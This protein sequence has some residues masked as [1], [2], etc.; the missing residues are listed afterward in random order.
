MIGSFEQIIEFI[1][2]ETDIHAFDFEINKKTKFKAYIFIKNN[3]LNI[4]NYNLII[5]YKN[6]NIIYNDK[7]NN[8]NKIFY[9]I[10]EKGFYIIEIKSKNNEKIKDVIYLKINCYEKIKKDNNNNN[11]ILNFGYKYQDI[12]TE[13]NFI[14]EF[15]TKFYIFICNNHINLI[16]MPYEASIYYNLN[17]TIKNYYFYY[18]NTSFGFYVEVIFKYKWVKTLIMEYR[19][20]Y[21]YYFIYTKFGSFKCS[22]DFYFY[23]FDNE[24]TNNIFRGNYLKD[25]ILWSETIAFPNYSSLSHIIFNNI[26][27]LIK[28]NNKIDNK[29]FKYNN[30]LKNNDLI[31][32]HQINKKIDIIYL[33]DSTGS[34]GEEVNNAS[35]LAID[36]ADSL[37]KKYP[38]HDF[39]FGFIYYNDPIDCLSDFND[40]LQLTKDMEEIKNFCNNWRIQGGGDEAEDWAGG[41]SIALNEIKWRDGRRIIVHICD[42]PSH[43]AKFSKNA[44]DNHRGKEFEDKLDDLIQKCAENKIEI[45]GIYKN[46]SAKN[47]FLECK[48]I[49]ENNRGNAFNIQYYNPKLPLN[50]NI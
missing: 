39:Q 21:K 32:N 11:S 8:N 46:D 33:I 30:Y 35:N 38:Y 2:N 27:N 22:R 37:S 31:N 40:F 13:I 24:F 50:I 19:Y 9:E 26:D 36:N 5:K 34:M 18:I 45:I 20:E 41:Y 7:I 3:S 6:G 49:Y 4:N 23:D 43:G 15:I 17:N 25:K 12:Y 44:G 14:Q 28:E 47:C 16:E 42:A 48:N 1:P 10:L 29:N